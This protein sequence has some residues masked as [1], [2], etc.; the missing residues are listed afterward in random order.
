M[1][2]FDE[3]IRQRMESDQEQLEDTFFRMASVVLDRWG[4]RQ[5]DNERIISHDAVNNILKFYHEKP[6]ELP[7]DIT[8]ADK[9][10]EFA[11]RPSGLMIRDVYLEKG[12]HKDGFGPMLG[13]LKESHKAVA[14]I[15]GQIYGYK[16]RDP[17]TGKMVRVTRKTA[18]LFE[19]EALCVY[20]PLPAKQLGIPDLLKYLKKCISRGDLILI[21]LASLAVTLV[22]MLEPRI[23]SL[24][25]GTVLKS[26]QINLLV[27]TGAF[28]VAAAFA[29]QMINVIKTFLT[30]RISTKTSVSVEA[31]VMM[32]ILS[33][34]VSFFRKYSSGEL[35]SRVG[36]VNTLCSLIIDNVLTMGIG[37]LVSLLYVTQIFRYAPALVLPSI[38]IVVLTMAVSIGAS[39]L[40]IRIAR[41]KMQCAAEESGVGYAIL[42]GI[43]KIKL[44]GAEKRAFSR[45]G[46]LYAKNARLEYNPPLFLKVSPVLV[47]AISLMGTIVLYFIAVKTG[48][49]VNQYYAFSAAFG[50]LMAAFTALSGIA[51]TVAGIRPVLEMAEPILKE[52]PEINGDK[53]TVTGVSGHIELNHIDFRYDEKSPYIF[54]DISLSIRP[55]EY[56]AIV[57]RTGCGKSTLVRL[58]LG[59]EKPEKGTIFYDQYDIGHTDPRSLRKQIGVVTQSGELFPGDILSNITISAPFLS[60][61][62][63]W[64]AAEIAGIAEDIRKMPMGMYTMIC[65]GQGGVSGG[66]KQRLMIARA[67]APKPKILIL[68]EATSALDNKTQKQVSEALDKMNCTRIV[69]AH[70]LSTIRH[71]DRILMLQDGVVIEEGTYEELIQQNGEFAEMVARQQLDPE[72]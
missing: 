29:S 50:R 67:V 62:E 3:Q 35:S 57:G 32:R 49:E 40:Q 70:R 2:Y 71:C 26:K 1:S 44:A 41:Q 68:D 5:L 39:L 58:L 20:Q 59:F 15:P 24:L 61:E 30:Q 17:V 11:F 64:E 22:G 47:T 56:V 27:G 53:T 31:S 42:S 55:G 7:D 4:E 36:A 60:M 12:W 45:W 34:P 28:L 63:A 43:Q 69:I 16:F 10:L 54:Q 37:G 46:N 6:V 13:Y 8:D 65:E 9:T 48:V 23:Y 21:I 38:L 66:Q 18:E 52:A 19:R 33:L 25:T 72:A 14:L 51:V